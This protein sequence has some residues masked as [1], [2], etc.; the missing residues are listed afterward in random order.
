MTLSIRLS[1][2]LEAELAALCRLYGQTKSEIIKESL[3]G[4]IEAKKRP[5]HAAYELGKELFDQVGSG[6]GT[7]SIHRKRL[8]KEKLREKGAH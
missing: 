8:L 3:K 6:H 7:L 2:N 5:L 4:Y 1:P